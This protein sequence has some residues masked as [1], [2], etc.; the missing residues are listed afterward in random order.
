MRRIAAGVGVL[1]ACQGFAQTPAKPAPDVVALLA[2]MRAAYSNVKTAQLSSTFLERKS[3]NT[4]VLKSECVYL[5]PSS[6][7]IVSQGPDVLGARK[8]VLVAD[9]KHI[10]VEGLP[11][12][13]MTHRYTHRDMVMNLPQL[14]LDVLCLWDWKRQLSTEPLGNMSQSKLK[15]GTDQWNG[16]TYTILDETA[17]QVRVRYFVDPVSSLIM[18]TEQ[19]GLGDALPDIVVT[20][21]KITL[22]GNVNPSQFKIAA[23][24]VPAVKPPDT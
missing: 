8:Y 20:I 14:N 18:R 13:P 22:D 6:F 19:F 21:D 16:K 12:G 15:I 10:H 4:V 9:G 3:D 7:R 2:K 23:P 17:G 11:G 1:L 24:V 5:A